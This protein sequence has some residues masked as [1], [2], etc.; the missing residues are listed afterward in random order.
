MILTMTDQFREESP[1]S[2]M[3]TAGPPRHPEWSLADVTG[4]RDGDQYTVERIFKSAWPGLYRAAYRILLD[5][6]DAEEAAQDGFVRAYRARNGFRGSAG[7]ELAAWLATIVRRAA[8]DSLRRSGKLV[9]LP[10]E[11]P[12]PSDD[13]QENALVESETCR[14]VRTALQALDPGDRA[15]LVLCEVEELPQAEIAAGL[16]ISVGAFKVRLHRARRRFR[17]AYLKVAGLNE[18][19]ALVAAGGETNG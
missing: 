7:G 2:A 16:E 19:A 4:F 14:E 3:P 1:P 18:K 11:L 5:H 8:L 15:A 17:E 10:D 13:D 12:I 6:D 9:P